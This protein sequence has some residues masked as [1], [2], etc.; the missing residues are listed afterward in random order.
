MSK[1]LT[2]LVAFFIGILPRPTVFSNCKS[3]SFLSVRRI[4]SLWRIFFSI[5][6]H[7]WLLH[8]LVSVCVCVCLLK[9]SKCHSLAGIKERKENSIV[10]AEESIKYFI[11]RA[12]KHQSSCYIE[13][14]W[15]RENLFISSKEYRNANSCNCRLLRD[16]PLSNIASKASTAYIKRQESNWIDFSR[17]LTNIYIRY[18]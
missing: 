14:Q 6:F 4:I 9:N 13:F 1:Y 15:K 10:E 8:W 11:V 2:R 18:I 5:V 7:E 3:F 12:K 16:F 17:K